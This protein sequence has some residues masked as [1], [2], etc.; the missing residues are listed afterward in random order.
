[1]TAPSAALIHKAIEA[2]FRNFIP[3][4]DLAAAYALD[5]R[6]DEASRPWRKPPPQSNLTVKWFFIAHA[7]N[8][9]WTMDGLRKAWLPE[10]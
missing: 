5:G 8:V 4:A 2:G 9:P 1:M 10:E 3:Y 6:M 7:P